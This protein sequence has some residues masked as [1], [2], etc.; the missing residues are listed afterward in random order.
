V[1]S[2]RLL[3]H[4]HHALDAVAA[5]TEGAAAITIC[6][7]GAKKTYSHT[8]PN[9]DAACF[10]FGP[11]GALVAVADGH[12]GS[13]GAERAVEWLLTKLAVE[14]TTTDPGEASREAWCASA[15]SALQAVHREVI[16]QG[17]E[18]RVDPAPTTLSLALVRPDDDLLLHASV[19]DSHVFLASPD[20]ADRHVARDVAWATTGKN[21]CYFAGESYEDGDLK[22]PHWV[23]GCEPIGGTRAVLLA[24]DG[25][26]EV[27][28]GVEDPEEAAARAVDHA[29]TNKPALR[30]LEASRHLTEAALGAHRENRAGDNICTAVIWLEEREA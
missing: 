22:E 2:A 4:Q 11:R 18:L 10:A 14:W 21:R 12:H 30:P 9:E 27:R 17:R 24:T 26:S 13:R 29:T 3:G 1:R 15:K 5:I 25:L 16:A 28:I 7:G 19:G 6:R 8:D 23:V 20:T